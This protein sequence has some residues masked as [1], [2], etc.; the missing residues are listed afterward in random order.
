M[1]VPPLLDCS[2]ISQQQRKTEFIHESSLN[3]E[4]GPLEPAARHSLASHFTRTSLRSR[5][6][7]AID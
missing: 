4:H 7:P 1:N 3:V 2:N 6:L 5:T